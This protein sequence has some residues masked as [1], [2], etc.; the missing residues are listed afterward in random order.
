VNRSALTINYVEAGDPTGD[1]AVVLVHGL[2]GRWQ[3]WSKVIPA[4]ST[5]RRVLALDLPGFGQ[6]SLPATGQLDLPAIADAIAAVV[7]ALEIH[8]LTFVGHSF[9]GPLGTIFATR[10][11]GVT[12]RLVLVAG[13]VQ[14]FQR[15]LSAELRPWCT[16]PL[17]AIASVAELAYTATPI[18]DPLRGPISRSSVL[19]RLALWPFVLAPRRLGPEDARLMI[20]GAGAQ[21]VWPTAR[22]IARARGWDRLPVDVPV[23]LINGDH[24]LIAPLSDLRAYRGRVDQALVVK[25]TGHMPMIERPDA[26]LVALKQALENC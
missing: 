24:D 21:G 3:H 17:T 5:R 13:T 10:H 8:R 22:A 11:R 9:G 16:R 20:D 19:R 26:F 23:T 4:I 25:E 12:K 2:G 14:S 18:P 15:T 7:H 6:S 1:P